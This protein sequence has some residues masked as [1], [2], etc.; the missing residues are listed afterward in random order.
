MLSYSLLHGV[1]IL[2]VQKAIYPPVPRRMDGSKKEDGEFGELCVNTNDYQE[3]MKRFNRQVLEYYQAQA[4][5]RKSTLVFCAG[6]GLV[7]DLALQFQLAGVETRSLSTHTHAAERNRIVNSFRKGDF[8][9]LINCMMLIEG[10][11]AP[12]VGKS[13]PLS[14]VRADTNRLIA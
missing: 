7:E 13:S 10:Y 6:I 8:P 1:Y 11:D 5:G 14:K 3:A 2:M 4:K 12:Q 9:V